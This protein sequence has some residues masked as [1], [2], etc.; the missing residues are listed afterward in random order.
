MV[1][2]MSRGSS[3]VTPTRPVTSMKIVSAVMGEPD[4]CGDSWS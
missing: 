2:G 4:T 1:A 3:I